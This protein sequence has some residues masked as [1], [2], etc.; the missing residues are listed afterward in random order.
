[1]SEAEE[2]RLGVPDINRLRKAMK[3]WG[4]CGKPDCHR[5][6]HHDHQ[7]CSCDRIGCPHDHSE[8][9]KRQAALNR[10]IDR[11]MNRP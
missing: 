3:H 6:G 11:E 7:P 9:Y 2:I 8:H 10:L 5:T 1:M 4:G